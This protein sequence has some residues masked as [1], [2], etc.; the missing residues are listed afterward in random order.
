MLEKHFS[1]AAPTVLAKELDKTKDRE[2]KLSKCNQE[3]IT[4]FKI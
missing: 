2:K 1:V 3:W 4:S